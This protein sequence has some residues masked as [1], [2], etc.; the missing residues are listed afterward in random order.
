MKPALIVNENFP[1]PA[2]RL[3]RLSGVDV[4]SVQET[5]PGASDEEVLAK[6]TETGRGLVAG[7]RWYATSATAAAICAE[8]SRMF[9]IGG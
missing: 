6:A 8:T 9:T 3:L 7:T 4:L 2:V 5:M 1:V